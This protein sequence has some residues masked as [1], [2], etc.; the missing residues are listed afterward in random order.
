[1]FFRNLTSNIHLEAIYDEK[2][3]HFAIFSLKHDIFIDKFV[4]KSRK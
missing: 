3:I 2:H 4:K 1:M